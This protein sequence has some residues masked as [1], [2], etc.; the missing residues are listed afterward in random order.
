MGGREACDSHA[1]EDRTNHA[2]EP[3]TTIYKIFRAAEWEAAQ[4]SGSFAGSSDDQ[5]DGFIHFSTAEQLAGTAAKHFAGEAG[6]VLAAVEADLLGPAL[7]WE[8]SR[9]GQLFPHLYGVLPLASVTRTWPLPVVDG[10]H[11]FPASFIDGLK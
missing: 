3:V 1:S 4:G 7:R 11:R 8:P 5:R 2:G 9:N 6:L 10:A